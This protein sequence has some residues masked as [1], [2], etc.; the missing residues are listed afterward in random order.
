MDLDEMQDMLEKAIDEYE[1]VKVSADKMVKQVEDFSFN[2]MV[3]SITVRGL[4]ASSKREQLQ[5]C[6]KEVC[7]AWGVV[8]GRNHF[9]L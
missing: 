9:G 1:V 7:N 8:R 5:G 3:D 2:K 6:L 4:T